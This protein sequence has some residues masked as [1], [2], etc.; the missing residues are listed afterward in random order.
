MGVF[1]NVFTAGPG[2]IYSNIPWYG[3][4][5]TYYK[6]FPEVELRRS[7]ISTVRYRNG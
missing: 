5:Q 2:L 6:G 7:G 4:V 1:Q 3:Q